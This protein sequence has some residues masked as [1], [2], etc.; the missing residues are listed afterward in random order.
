M[1]GA[2]DYIN[3]RRS[4]IFLFLVTSLILVSMLA[5]IL[6]TRIVTPTNFVAEAETRQINFTT[7]DSGSTRW[8]LPAS[9]II[10]SK[11]IAQPLSYPP[12][13][14]ELGPNAEV[15][16]TQIAA[17]RMEV[18]VQPSEGERS[19]RPYVRLLFDGI[20][21]NL[22]T[23]HDGV[24]IAFNI[25]AEEI[26]FA[27]KGKFRVGGV[28][29]EGSRSLP[30]VLLYG[31]LNG[32]SS[33]VFGSEVVA[34]LETDIEEGSRILSH[35]EAMLDVTPPTES[36]I[37]R[38]ITSWFDH[39]S[40]NAAATIRISMKETPGMSV[41]LWRRANA[42]GIAPQVALAAEAPVPVLMTVPIWPKIIQS[43]GL[44][45]IFLVFIAA[46]A[47]AGLYSNCRGLWRN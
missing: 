13:I 38:W 3:I 42:I 16:V 47:L 1:S 34:F 31:K 19:S 12:G 26:A 35:P 7:P 46:G 29:P 10:R 22:E 27:A 43:P 32:R 18:A 9:T 11:S 14:L 5:W 24:R 2:K 45:A 44:Q 36:R 6:G 8:A 39:P 25:P 17:G 28:L 20:P 4:V 40:E 37:E 21:A 23:P 15:Y 41:V 30:P 33:P